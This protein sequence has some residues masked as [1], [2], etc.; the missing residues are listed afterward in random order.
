MKND[1]NDGWWRECGRQRDERSREKDELRAFQIFDIG[2][3]ERERIFG[4]KRKF[5]NEKN[6]DYVR[7]R[8]NI[9]NEEGEKKRKNLKKRISGQKKVALFSFPASFGFWARDLWPMEGLTSNVCQDISRR[10]WRKEGIRQGRREG[11]PNETRQSLKF[12]EDNWNW[13]S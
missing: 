6:L 5:F 7:W 12:G 10:E 3:S 11:E 9:W 2:P 4:I 1:W 8:K 13:Q